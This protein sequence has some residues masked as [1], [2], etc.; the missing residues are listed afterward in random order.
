MYKSY[1]CYVPFEKKTYNIWKLMWN[2]L[3][4]GDKMMKSAA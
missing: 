3:W 2:H 1:K 4:Q